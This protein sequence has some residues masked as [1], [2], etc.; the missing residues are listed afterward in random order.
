MSASPGRNPER[1]EA[2]GPSR[3]RVVPDVDGL[4]VAAIAVVTIVSVEHESGCTGSETSHDSDDG[5]DGETH[6]EEGRVS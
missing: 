5:S 1:P 6:S 3:A 2:F 4:E